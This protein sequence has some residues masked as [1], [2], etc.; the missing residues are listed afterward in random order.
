MLALKA[1]DLRDEGASADDCVKFL[2][3]RKINVNTWYTTDALKYLKRSGRCSGASA[4]IGTLLKICPILNLD[5][6]GHLIV[7]K[8]VRGLD[9]TLKRIHDIIKDNVTEPEKQ[10][11]FVCH[12]DIPEKAK[13][14]GESLKNS[15]G[16][17]DVYYTY[18]G[19]IIGAHC[20]PGLMAAFYFGNLRDTKGYSE[21]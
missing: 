20:G 2:E 10:T 11:L 9:K 6:K 12:S 18:I 19:T 3:E 13:E 17:K 14:F 16:F 1:A 5:A 21:K 4:V 8:R 15:I 7:Q